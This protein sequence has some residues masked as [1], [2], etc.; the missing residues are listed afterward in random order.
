MK[1]TYILI[2]LLF[3]N[4]STAQ[5]QFSVFFESNKFDLTTKEKN[6]L[7]QWIADNKTAKIV[8]IY[9]FTDEDGSRG[10]NDT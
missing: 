10:Y 4:I 9:G 5:E 8:G 6:S 2:F 1:F 7:N 3:A